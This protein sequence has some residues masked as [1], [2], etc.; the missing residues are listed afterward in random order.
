[1]HREKILRTA[2]LEGG[3]AHRVS[4]KSGELHQRLRPERKEMGV[5]KLHRQFRMT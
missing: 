4:T 3:K 1:M 2:L 5:G